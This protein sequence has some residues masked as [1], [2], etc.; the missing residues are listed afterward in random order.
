MNPLTKER[1]DIFQR[2]GHLYM[3][4]AAIVVGLAGAVGAVLFRLM[5]RGVQ[6]VAFGGTEGVHDLIAAGWLDE[7]ED[8]IHWARE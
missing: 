4:I 7:P 8:P 5:I 2:G 3:V 6:A 1:S